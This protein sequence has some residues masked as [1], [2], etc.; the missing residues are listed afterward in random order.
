MDTH[1]HTYTQADTKLFFAL[2]ASVPLFPDNLK[3][4]WFEAWRA[5]LL[6]FYLH[7][8]AC[9]IHQNMELRCANRYYITARFQGEAP[10]TRLADWQSESGIRD[11]FTP[12]FCGSSHISLFLNSISIIFKSMKQIFRI[13]KISLYCSPRPSQIILCGRGCEEGVLHSTVSPC[14]ETFFFIHDIHYSETK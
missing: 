8:S 5:V 2:S 11:S 13:T 3:I 6:S 1:N 14:V 7:I 4:L 12:T 10:L 9:R